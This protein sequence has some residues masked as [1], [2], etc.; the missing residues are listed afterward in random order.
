MLLIFFHLLIALALWP[1]PDLLQ[2]P[3][4]WYLRF[5]QWEYWPPRSGLGIIEECSPELGLGW[6]HHSECHWLE[7]AAQP[8]ILLRQKVAEP[9]QGL[10]HPFSRTT[11]L[12]RYCFQPMPLLW[13]VKR[14][15]A[16]SEI[17]SV[18]SKQL[19]LLCRFWSV[20]LTNTVKN[21]L[22]FLNWCI[23]SF[24]LSFW[25]SPPWKANKTIK[26]VGSPD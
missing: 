16:L 25:D 12:G 26:M 14:H 5:H 18:P 20:P 17:I 24:F 3:K 6:I 22:Q 13:V 15:K 1:R 23:F 9:R 8:L 19:S 10:R 2:H 21:D 7:R 4:D 11:L